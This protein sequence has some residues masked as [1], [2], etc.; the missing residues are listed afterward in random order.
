MILNAASPDVMRGCLLWLAMTSGSYMN[1]HQLRHYSTTE[2]IT[3]GVDVRTVA[4]RLGHCGGGSTALRAYT[5]WVAE[6]DQRAMRASSV[7][8][9]SPPIS[10]LKMAQPPT[11]VLLQST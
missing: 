3:A 5:A 1:L 6:S 7:R 11:D 2:L 8:M 4:G 10:G 9:P